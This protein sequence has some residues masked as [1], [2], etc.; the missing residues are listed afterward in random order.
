MRSVRTGDVEWPTVVL[1]AG[2]YTLFLL[3]TWFHASI[4]WWIL[5]PL[6]AVTVAF[7]GS[8]QH[9]VLH[10]HPFHN[11][12]FDDLLGKPALWLWLPY[13]I[14]RELH[15]RHHRNEVLTDP[16]D[17]PE[18]Y[19]VTR[20]RWDEQSGIT[21]QVLLWNHT[22]LGRLIL[23]PFLAIGG[24]W[25]TQVALLASGDRRHWQ[26]WLEHAFWVA[27]LLVW[28]MG[29]CGMPLWQYVLLFALP[30]TSLSLV[31]SYMEHRPAADPGAR[32][33]IVEDRG[34]LSLL[35]LNNNL[36][37][38][39]HRWPGIPWY[40]IPQLYRERRD[41]ILAW[42]KGYLIPGYGTIVA[43]YLVRPKDHPIH[44]DYV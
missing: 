9:E 20:Q 15:L 24:F 31:R 33:A 38:V 40:K 5:L 39:H 23:G 28:I 11:R 41:E 7:Q 16:L 6:G 44:P 34:F 3:L 8:L 36:H 43:R 21:R 29:V 30:G 13:E 35:F 12:W 42:N 10:G 4:P 27:L 32:C 14:Y 1:A 18:S 37:A 25:R 17:D 19:Y 26:I 22:L 2:I